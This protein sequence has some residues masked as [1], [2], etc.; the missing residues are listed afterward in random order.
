MA[1]PLRLLLLVLAAGVCLAEARV[2][3]G[4][5]GA[6]LVLVV[7]D[8]RAE[9]PETRAETPTAAGTDNIQAAFL[10][11]MTSDDVARGVYGLAAETGEVA[12]TEAQR[13]TIRPLL[14]E[15][16]DLRARLGEL[17]AARRAARE[18]WLTAGGGMV[19][20]VGAERA[21]AVTR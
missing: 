19:E 15:G 13:A 3:A 1:V 20:A 17:R 12:L 14:V 21:R 7:P 2:L 11:H 16:A 18:A 4:R 6:G 9:A 8:T 10:A 5:G